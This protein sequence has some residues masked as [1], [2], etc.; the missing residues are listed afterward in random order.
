MGGYD[1][2]YAKPTGDLVAAS[3]GRLEKIDLG[4]DMR[5]SRDGETIGTLR[6]ERSFFPS[7]DPTL[8]PVS[9][10]FEGEATSEVGLNAGLRRDVWSAISPNVRDLEKQIAEGDRVFD[11]RGRRPDRHAARHGARPGARRADAAPT[12]PTRRRRRSA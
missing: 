8:G 11:G 2:T 5:V 12:P 3:N 1:I 10:F 6:T 4:A 7:A 9:R